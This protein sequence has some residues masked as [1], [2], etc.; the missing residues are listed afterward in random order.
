MALASG[1]GALP[2]GRLLA[3]QQVA[4]RHLSLGQW[5]GDGMDMGGGFALF[6]L[7]GPRIF[8]LFPFFVVLSPKC[9]SFKGEIRRQKQE[10]E[11]KPRRTG[12]KEGGE[13]DAT[14]MPMPTSRMNT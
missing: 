5:D 3:F 12:G 1:H 14:I 9:S 7:S 6:F 8:F 10:R 2:A 13:Y 11:E 4:L